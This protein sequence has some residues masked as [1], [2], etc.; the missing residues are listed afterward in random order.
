MAIF[1]RIGDLKKKK[2]QFKLF[3]MLMQM[4]L[5]KP[6][7]MTSICATVICALATAYSLPKE[8]FKEVLNDMEKKYEEV[9]DDELAKQFLRSFYGDDD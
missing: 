7:E 3:K 5:N 4:G 8:T 6:N 9:K 2:N 1:N